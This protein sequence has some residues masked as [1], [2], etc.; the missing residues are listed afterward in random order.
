[1][2]EDQP[3]ERQRYRNMLRGRQTHGCGCVGSSNRR[4]GGAEAVVPA[5]S[6]G[7]RAEHRRRLIGSYPQRIRKPSLLQALCLKQ[8]PSSD[9]D[10]LGNLEE[11]IRP[12]R[13]I[14][15]N[16]HF[17]ESVTS[18]VRCKEA[19]RPETVICRA[20]Q[21][22]RRWSRSGGLPWIAD[23]S[24]GSRHSGRSSAWTPVPHPCT[25]RRWPALRS[26][27]CLVKVEPPWPKIRPA[28]WRCWHD[29]GP[30]SRAACRRR[31]ACWC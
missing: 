27:S 12:R 14:P 21:G 24:R 4:P 9:A 17:S 7:G 23:D 31:Q 13:E 15:A 19:A 29:E 28:R 16:R 3:S 5:G 22:A 2:S 18:R 6:M 8:R 1:M 26:V 11:V 25:G 30:A 20:F 10:L